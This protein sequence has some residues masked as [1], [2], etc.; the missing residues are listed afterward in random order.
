MVDAP[1]SSCLNKTATA[2]IL[3]AP[4]LLALGDEARIN[5]PGIVDDVNWTWRM[6]SL[7]ELKKRILALKEKMKASNRL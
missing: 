3:C 2:A 1:S 7:T 4:D 5:V 6:D